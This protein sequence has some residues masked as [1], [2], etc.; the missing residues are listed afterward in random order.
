MKKRSYSVLL[1]NVPHLPEPG[2]LEVSPVCVVCTPLLWS[3]HFFL[4]CSCLLVVDRVWSLWCYWVSLEPPSVDTPS[5]VSHHV[6]AWNCRH[7]FFCFSLWEALI[8]GWGLQ[9]DLMSAP[10]HCWSCSGTDECDYLPLSLRQEL[11]WCGAGPYWGCLHNATLG[12]H[13]WTPVA[14]RWVGVGQ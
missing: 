5:V 8:G 4:Q 12:A 1:C 2:A 11:L 14:D 3:N 13:L 10:A 6:V 9:L 7:F